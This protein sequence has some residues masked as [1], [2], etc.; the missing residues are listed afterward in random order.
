[1]ALVTILRCDDVLAQHIRSFADM[2]PYLVYREYK[3]HVRPYPLIQTDFIQFLVW[4]Y[5]LVA[6]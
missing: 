2:D 4:L 5:Q 1:M 3:V 6:G